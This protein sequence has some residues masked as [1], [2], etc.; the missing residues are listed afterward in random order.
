MSTPSPELIA[1]L[2]AEL[3]AASQAR[4]EVL[5]RKDVPQNIARRS[6]GAI[7][8]ALSASA[9]AAA[10]HDLYRALQAS[11]LT[12][13]SRLPVLDP[14]TAAHVADMMVSA[15]AVHF[16]GAT[17]YFTKDGQGLPQW[18]KNSVFGDAALDGKRIRHIS[19]KSFERAASDCGRILALFKTVATERC[20][21]SIHDGEGVAR[22]AAVGLYKS[23]GGQ[24]VYFPTLAAAANA[25]RDRLICQRMGWGKARE[26]AEEFGL[27]QVRIHQIY[28]AYLK[29]QKTGAKASAQE[30]AAPRNDEHP[31][32]ASEPIAAVSARPRSAERIRQLAG[33]SIQATA[34]GGAPIFG[35]AQRYARH[36]HQQRS[37]RQ[38]LR[39]GNREGDS[40]STD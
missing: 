11:M 8:Q 26:L 18:L 9:T 34:E 20:E 32:A 13:I 19:P 24:H 10:K 36:L 35:S 21:L 39:Q 27:S 37:D 2:S 16:G 40:D 4:G 28:R 12:E 38:A 33:Q 17:V 1:K 31:S 25:E 22:A 6:A 15:T 7:A 23:L 29:R 14:S 5:A 3:S 30:P